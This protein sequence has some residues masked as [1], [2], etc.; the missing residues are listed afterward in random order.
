MAGLAEA[1]S[2]NVPPDVF[3]RHWREIR[4]AKD[5]HAETGMALARAKKAAKGSGIDLDAFK[6]LEKLSDL[7]ADE[8]EMQFRHLRIYAK[9]IEL[10]AGMQAALFGEDDEPIPEPDA[11]V[12]QHQRDFNATEAGL[13]A[14]KSGELRGANTHTPGSSEHVAWD[15][16]WLKG[17]RVWLKAQ[18]KIA[19]EMGPRGHG[20]REQSDQSAGTNS[21]APSSPARRGRKP[22][23]NGSADRPLL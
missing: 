20:Q 1:T 9:W 17:N 22:K 16:A 2:H 6:M 8:M 15:K 18:Q 13:A 14:G 7:D 19:S 10:P 23:S 12:I 5:A 3:V 4:T 21:T 11:T